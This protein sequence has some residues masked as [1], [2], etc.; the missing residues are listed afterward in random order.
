MA[1]KNTDPAAAGSNP[2]NGRVVNIAPPNFQTAVFKITGTAP[3]V[4]NKFSQKAREQMKAK[5]E[6]GSQGKK[7]KARE[8][9]D[10]EACYQQARHISTKGWD[11]IPAATFRKAM[12]GACRLVDFK[13]TL[14]RIALHVEADGFDADEGTPLVRIISKDGPRRMESLVRNETGVADIR[15]RPQWLEWGAVLR[16]RFDASIF[17]LEDITN[18]VA[19]AG[20]Q[21][22]ICEGRPSSESGGC[23][24]GLFEI[25]KGAA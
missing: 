15:I 22:G 7:G 5:Q 8:P 19:R 24:W 9:K 25:M 4:I 10:F 20:G 2:V 6:A 16:V 17:S 21:C 13:M 3:L 14:A 23:G 1:T 18:L 11:G 12:I